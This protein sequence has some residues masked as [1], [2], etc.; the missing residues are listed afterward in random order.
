MPNFYEFFAGGGMAR[1]GL[2]EEWSC[3][4]ANDFS[5]QKANSYRKN[6]GDDHLIVEDINK[7]PTTALLVALT[8]RGPPSLVRIFPLLE[9]EPV[10]R[11]SGRV[12][13]GD[14]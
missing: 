2:G 1:S 8:W 7:I 9:M 3:V 5:E 6:W 11:G 10:L 4:F 13:F 12:R 14:F